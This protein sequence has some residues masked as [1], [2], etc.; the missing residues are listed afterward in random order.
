MTQEE[1]NRAIEEKKAEI[2]R[3]QKEIRCLRGAR[4]LTEYMEEDAM[5]Y[6]L[7]DNRVQVRNVAGCYDQWGD[8][9]KTCVRIFKSHPTITDLT[10]DQKK[11]CAKM[12]DEIIRIYNAY[13]EKYNEMEE[14]K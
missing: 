5:F 13:F 9:R 12:A 14:E 11:I 4:S 7:S 3:L 1:A 10:E 8:I 2:Q 6:R